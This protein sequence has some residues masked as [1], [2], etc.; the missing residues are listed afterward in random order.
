MGSRRAPRT[1]STSTTSRRST[2]SGDSRRC[3]ETDR[4][5]AAQ[6]TRDDVLDPKD[7]ILLGFTLDPRTGLG[8]FQRYFVALVGWLKK[9]SIQD[10]L[11][12]PEVQE[13]IGRMR[14]QDQAFPRADPGPFE[15]GWERPLHRLQERS[16][17]A[18]RQPILRVH[19]VSGGE[20]LASRPSRTGPRAHRRHRRSLHL[21][22]QQPHQ[23]WRADVALRWRGA[24]R[25]RHLPAR[26]REGGR[27]AADRRAD[28]RHEAGRLSPSPRLGGTPHHQRD[29][30]HRLDRHLLDEGTR[31]VEPADLRRLLAPLQVDQCLARLL[32]DR[33]LRVLAD[34]DLEGLDALAS[35]GRRTGRC[36]RGRT[37]A[38]ARRR[39]AARARAR[40]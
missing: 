36:G 4:L 2:R 20:H 37:A 16:P 35:C 8:A 34:D 26:Q 14:D 21:R 31:A 3:A 23:R 1:S 40:P 32:R 15:A 5:D 22:S 12:Q 6:L 33:A 38:G 11:Q 30:A 29:E 13:R 18:G 10:V 27:R 39:S 17:A 19:A 28:R 25:R 24:S 9:M 7:Y